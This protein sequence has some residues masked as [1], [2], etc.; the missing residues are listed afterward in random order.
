MDKTAIKN[1]A[2]WARNKLIADIHYRAGLLGITAEGIANP[3]PQSTGDTEFYDIG[4]AE[5]YS[6]H[7]Q[8]VK[9]RKRLAELLNKKAE[10]SDYATAYKYVL[11]EVAYTWF[12]RLIAI[13]FM[14]VNDYLPSH[15]RVLSSETGR[16]EPDLV[17]TPFDADLEFTE[18]E[19]A[20][21]IQMKQDN[22][23]DELFRLLFIKECNAL[24]AILPAL[25]E[26]TNDYT[27][28]LLSISVIDKEGVVYHLVNDIPEEDFDVEKGGQVE[29]IGWLY[30]Y[31]NTEPKAEVFGRPSGT[32][33]KKEDIPAATQLFT[34]DWIV[35]YMVENSLGRL[36]VEGHPEQKDNFLPSEA[37]QTAYR[38]DHSIRDGKWHYYLEEAE[39]EPEVQE[40]LAEICKEYAELNPEDIRCI[41]PCM[42]SGHILVYLFDVL[43]QIYETQGY[44][45][46]DAAQSILKNNLYGLDID[47]RAAQMAY[48]A[49]MMKAR[50]YDRRILTR[51]IVPHVY[52]IQES[53]GINREQLDYFGNSL[54]ETEKNTARIQMEKLLDTLVDAKEYGSILQVENYAWDLLRCFVDDANMS[55]QISMNTL[56][57]DDTQIRLRKLVEIGLCLAQKYDVVVTNPPYMVPSSGGNK[58]NEYV[59]REY[60]NSKADMFSVFIEW[61]NKHIRENGLQATITQHSWMFL[62]SFEKL[63]ELVFLSD[64]INMV[65]LGAHG[66]DEI[67]GEVVQTTAFCLR[68]SSLKEYKATYCRLT[69][70]DSQ[71]KKEKLFL[72]TVNRFFLNKEILQEIPG[73]PFAYW[74]TENEFAAFSYDKLFDMGVT[75]RGL[76]TG[77]KDKFIQYWYEPKINELQLP[78]ENAGSYKWVIMNNGGNARKWYGEITNAV[79]WENNGKV[80]KST[81]KA[82]IPSEELYFKEC[83]TWNRISVGN[84]SVK[85]QE[86]GIIQGDMSP[87]FIPYDSDMLKYIMALMNSV[88]S[89]AMIHA[90]NPTITM[91]VGD[92]AKLPVIIS[93]KW[94]EKIDKIVQSNILISI[95]DWDSFETSWNFQHHPLIHKIPTIAK[96][97]DQWQV[98]CDDRFQQLKTNEEELNR[99]FIDIYGLQD[100]LTPE[101]EDKDV[102]IRKADLGRDVRSFISYAVGCMFG[103]YSLDVEGLAYAGGDWDSFKYTTYIPDADNILPI[104]DEEYFKDDIVGM[105]CAWVK[106]VYGPD[107]LEENLDFIANALGNKGNS[108]RE[109]IR[110]Y[111]LKDFFKDH[112][113][114]YQKRPIYWLFD[115]GKQN[116][117]KALV[118]LHRYN[119]DTIGNLRV[120]YLHRMQRVY[121]S[122]INRMQDMIDNSTNAREVAASTKRKDKLQKQLKECRE[123]DEKIG[124]LALSRTELDL[125]DGVKVNY[126]KVQTARDGKF[127]EVLADSKNIMGKQR[128]K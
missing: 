90:I 27:E 22:Q 96:A 87:F 97:F 89:T 120:D 114:T 82:I 111:F 10:E 49:V 75:R 113:K 54:N 91:P 31:Y 63:R 24:N 115:S 65:H 108:S 85:Y 69:Q 66:F 118:Y 25:F 58:L 79:L 5:P 11:E 127:Y 56:Y 59:K 18:T 88:V 26:K 124:H 78:K 51:G 105:F 41:D 28:L 13:R 16:V 81:G 92:I 14:E 20:L 15:I 3:L 37:E 102:T 29:I 73:C 94:K 4:T 43:M 100:E 112:C 19:R 55:G 106:K 68:K 62:S 67:G 40:Q 9:Q 21:V 38:E 123:Y 76:Q 77:N 33:I 39:Q 83:I 128:E 35:R 84:L 12:N 104:T 30:Q 121:E 110:N 52:A 98:E 1:F 117:F 42:G 109:V 107:T 44:T 60:P 71:D 72:D 45:R 6:I 86:P 46:R 93:A 34:P 17:T 126:R 95:V 23:L 47:D 48:F 8:A 57:L 53:N 2:I 99:I 80:I 122:E 101:I 103:R 36:W 61:C 116:G 125:D 119:A 70:G 64:V 74:L 7:G 32:K 50:Q